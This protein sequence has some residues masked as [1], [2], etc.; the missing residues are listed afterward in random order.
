MTDEFAMR[1][2]AVEVLAHLERHRELAVRDPDS[3]VREVEAALAPLRQSY[4]ESELPPSYFHA[5]E[6]ELSSV[7]PVAW[8]A[9]A[10]DFTALEARR[11]G[12]WRGGDLV[13]RLVYVLGGMVLGGLLVWLPFIPIWE[14]WV[15]FA[16]AFGGA[17]LPS[18]QVVWH[19][20]R[21]ARELGRIALRLG[22]SQAALEA[23]VQLNE[24]LP[25][26]PLPPPA[27]RGGGS[28]RG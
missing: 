27:P 15:P 14:K 21:Y 13:A 22:A 19:R 16:M 24:L 4:L 25:P 12:L 11:F 26:P 2:I 20:H 18:A 8:R 5:L 17:W 6:L 9:V 23:R 1:K 7:L 3:T 10:V 28:P